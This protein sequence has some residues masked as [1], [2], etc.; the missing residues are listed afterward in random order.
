MG[1]CVRLALTVC[2]VLAATPAIAAKRLALVFGNDVYDELPHLRKAVNDA[3]AMRDALAGLGYE[4]VACLLY[5]SP[6]PRD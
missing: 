3:N 5:T 4:V 1:R 6:S 2:L